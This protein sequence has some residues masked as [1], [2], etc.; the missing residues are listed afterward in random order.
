MLNKKSLAGFQV[1][2]LAASL[3][4]GAFP[5]VA[6]SGGFDVEI[7]SVML[8]GLPVATVDAEASVNVSVAVE[9]D[10]GGGSSNDWKSTG[11]RIDSGSYTCVDTADHTSSDGGTDTESFSITAPS[12]AGTYDVDIKV[13]K[14]DNC[15]SEQDSKSGNNNLIVEIPTPTPEPTSAD[16][17]AI[18][19][20]CDN[21][22][23]LPN[24][25]EGGPDITASTASDFLAE[26]E[27]CRLES[28]WDFQW[29]SENPASIDPGGSFI[30][31]T[32]SPWITFG[33]TDI[34]GVAITTIDTLSVGAFAWVREV[35]QS[36]YIP[37]TFDQSNQSNDD[38]VSAEMYCSIDVL[39]YDNIDSVDAPIAGETYYCVA[40][41]VLI[42]T[43]TP[44]S[45][46]IFF[47]ALG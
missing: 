14:N 11:Y 34:S 7:E 31:A 44:K 3:T 22:S 47:G 9:R 26:N 13:Y 6:N 33:P 40:F 28:G 8:N 5:L 41:N 2:F 23:D 30:G 17:V 29:A 18:K 4:S 1:L 25:G 24:W 35:L 42:P 37:F 21:E 39:N 27:N 16:I 15:S 45:T 36:G 43:P 38:N 32:G 20:V 46:L 12:S 10:S 19:I